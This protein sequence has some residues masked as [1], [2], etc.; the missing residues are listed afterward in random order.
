VVDKATVAVFPRIDVA[1]IMFGAVIAYL[2][3]KNKG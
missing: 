1:E 2:L 3:T